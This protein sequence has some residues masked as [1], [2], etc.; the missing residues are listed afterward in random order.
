M[1]W[2]MKHPSIVKTFGCVKWEDYYGI[3]MEYAPC[4]NLSSLILERKDIKFSYPLCLCLLK[5]IIDGLIYLHS[6]DV[7]HGDL[8][9]DNILLFRGLHAK[10]A[11]LGSARHPSTISIHSKKDYGTRGYIAPERYSNENIKLSSSMDVYRYVLL[12][13]LHIVHAH[14]RG[15]GGG[16]KGD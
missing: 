4:K 6:N 8:K 10:I 5:E 12:L 1:L 16:I 14:W 7:V 2:N 3:V 13:Y 11:D 9:P 15:Q